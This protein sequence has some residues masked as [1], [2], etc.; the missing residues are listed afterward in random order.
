MSTF[1]LTTH[2]LVLVLA[3]K[4]VC[5]ELKQIKDLPSNVTEESLFTAQSS[6]QH[7][8]VDMKKL[9]NNESLVHGL[10]VSEVM[11]GDILIKE[12]VKPRTDVIQITTK[13]T[14]LMWDIERNE[15]VGTLG[16]YD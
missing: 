10:K 9:L 14:L 11:P 15:E 13:D 3:D 12:R 2:Y 8:V 1:E 7:C 6:I 16:G 5:I 4:V